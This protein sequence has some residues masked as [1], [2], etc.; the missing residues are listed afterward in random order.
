[1]TT[2]YQITANV[3]VEKHGLATALTMAQKF[4]KTGNA[5]RVFWEYVAQCIRQMER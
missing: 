1:M 4:A 3:M 5:G 2:T